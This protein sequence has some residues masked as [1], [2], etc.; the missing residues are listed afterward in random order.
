MILLFLH[1]H[2]TSAEKFSFLKIKVFCPSLYS[3]DEGSFPVTT[4]SNMFL[5]GKDVNDEGLGELNLDFL[6]KG[7]Q[8]FWALFAADMQEVLGKRCKD[9]IILMKFP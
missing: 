7:L 1:P 5:I 6:V 4:E 9:W 2:P 8:N 3:Y